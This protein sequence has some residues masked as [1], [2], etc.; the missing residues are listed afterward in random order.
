MTK[1][2]SQLY[3][4]M[5]WIKKLNFVGRHRSSFWRWNFLTINHASNRTVSTP[6]QVLGEQCHSCPILDWHFKTDGYERGSEL[7]FVLEWIWWPLTLEQSIIKL[8]LALQSRHLLVI[9]NKTKQNP[10][11]IL[12]IITAKKARKASLLALQPISITEEFGTIS[13]LKVPLISWI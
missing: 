2:K 10:F 6:L 8:V 13:M 12:V 7:H 1:M 11:H 9:Q 5:P 3:G 4:K